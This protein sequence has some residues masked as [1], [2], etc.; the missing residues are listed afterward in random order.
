MSRTKNP[1]K[2]AL[3][4]LAN[5]LEILSR[6]AFTTLGAES[7]DVSDSTYA[8]QRALMALASRAFKLAH[9]IAIWVSNT[10]DVG[11]EAFDSDECRD[12][13]VEVSA[14]LLTLTR[15]ID[16]MSRT[17]S[18]QAWAIVSKVD[19]VLAKHFVDTGA[20]N[21]AV[22]AITEVLFSAHRH[23]PQY[24]DSSAQI[25]LLADKDQPF[26]PVLLAVLGTGTLAPLILA[27][28]QVSTPPPA[29]P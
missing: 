8:D 25:V 26:E 29:R 15:R 21:G 1:L 28:A 6:G 5:S 27:E 14:L 7:A 16:A 24:A 9:Q 17:R 2:E 11:K 18:A 13:V 19:R 4:T 20:F 22:T 3:R 10:M 12:I 23:D